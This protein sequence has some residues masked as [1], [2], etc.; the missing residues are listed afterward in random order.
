M[1]WWN[2]Y[3]GLS[4]AAKGRDRAGV[5]CWGLVRL[6]Y[7]EQLGITLP[8]FDAGYD[9]PQ[10]ARI[11]EMIARGREGWAK[12]QTPQPGDVVV[13]RILGGLNH[14]G[15]IAAPGTFLHVRAGHTAT[16]ERLDSGLWQHRVEGIY[17]YQAGFCLD[18]PVSVSGI[19]HPLRTARVDG[20]VPA[21]MSLAEI[22]QWM[23][24][25]THVPAEL[26]RSA[27]IMVN[28]EV[29]PVEK[30]EV[31][32]PLPGAHV[33]YRAVAQG[34]YWRTVMN[35]GVLVGAAL[36]APCATAQAL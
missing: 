17:R 12:T 36:L 25:Q 7:A 24:G 15:V 4:F 31:M 8:S 22:A 29:I 21:G 1:T 32:R 20:Q 9:S 5:D 13:L 35:I 34:D 26:S 6:V 3:V 28:G 18:L 19:A 30:W 11:E 27:I 16:I 33:A 10:D 14:V 2:S 23:R